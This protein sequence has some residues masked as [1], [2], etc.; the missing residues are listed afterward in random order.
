[1]REPA[2]KLKVGS[3]SGPKTLS[4][5]PLI[6]AKAEQ[7]HLPALDLGTQR[8]LRSRYGASRS[9]RLRSPARNP[10][11]PDDPHPFAIR[12]AATLIEDDAFAVAKRPSV[13]PSAPSSILAPPSPKSAAASESRSP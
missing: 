9:S 3:V 6:E 10:R 7:E 8:A 1:M 11:S 12:G 5:T 2:L 13:I 4:T